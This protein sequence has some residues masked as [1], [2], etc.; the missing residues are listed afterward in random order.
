MSFFRE[1]YLKEFGFQDPPVHD[2]L[3][4]F[5]L[6]APELFYDQAGNGPKRYRLDVVTADGAALGATVADFHEQLEG[7]TAGWGRGGRN[8]EV[9]EHL[10]V[11][12]FYEHPAEL[13][14]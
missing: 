5:Y 13:V 3:V 2:M 1:T 10:T 7:T 9:L 12:R 6:L 8:V 14:S 4:V 11:S